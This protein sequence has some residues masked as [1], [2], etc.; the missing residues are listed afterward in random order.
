MIGKSTSIPEQAILYYVRSIYPDAI[1]RHKLSNVN[2]K[3]YEADIFVP[4]IKAAI[5]YNGEHWH[6]SRE[7][8]DIEKNHVFSGLGIY[9]IVILEG[10]L[11]GRNIENGIIIRH[12]A[13][14]SPGLHMNEVIEETLHLLAKH[15]ENPAQK[16][17]ASN[18]T[19]SYNQY[20]IDYPNIV[21]RIFTTYCEDNITRY[22][23]FS[24]WD[25]EK[26][27]GI[28][29]TMIPQKTSAKFWYCCPSGYSFRVS[30][31]DY[32]EALDKCG[33]KCDVCAYNICPFLSACPLH[34]K[35]VEGHLPLALGICD[36]LQ[37]RI[38]NYVLGDGNW[39]RRLNNQLQILVSHA[40]TGLDLELL[41]K[42]FN[43]ET[44]TEEKKRILDVFC[45]QDAMLKNDG[46]VRPVMREYVLHI[47]NACTTDD[48]AL[49][50]RIVEEL[51]WTLAIRFS[52]FQD[53]AEKENAACSF[54][55]WTIKRIKHDSFKTKRYLDLIRL[56]FCSGNINDSFEKKLKT[57]LKRNRIKYD[58]PI[59]VSSQC[60]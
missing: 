39:P 55:E 9:S 43:L 56:P 53:G 35:W 58:L 5:E 30:P 52:N 8:R 57:I 36:Y 38:W 26:N 22:C 21:K 19:L 59:F 47:P 54:F 42:Y 10:N 29:P 51:D 27:R 14:G 44:T 6:S 11:K 34:T 60:K 46:Y 31:R 13:N 41:R 32:P 16:T 45:S 12:S 17:L 48:L 24:F 4:S 3:K 15:T 7:S 49:C 1:G 2:G 28:D 33:K 40:P 37:N 25:E 18:F 23:A 20:C 50:K